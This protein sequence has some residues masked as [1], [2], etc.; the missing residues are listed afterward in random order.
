M[1][2][3]SLLCDTLRGPRGLRSCMDS[4][5]AKVAWLEREYQGPQ[6]VVLTAAGQRGGET[7][8]M[9]VGNRRQNFGDPHGEHLGAPIRIHEPRRRGGS[10]HNQVAGGIPVA[11]VR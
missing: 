4:A 7:C 5:E 11:K 3:S 1:V 8:P 10:L 9:A 6:P 2:D